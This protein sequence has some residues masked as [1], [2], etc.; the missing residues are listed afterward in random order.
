MSR[1]VE[2]VSKKPNK[3]LFIKIRYTLEY[4]MKGFKTHKIHIATKIIFDKN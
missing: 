1:T 2:N 4:I 3:S